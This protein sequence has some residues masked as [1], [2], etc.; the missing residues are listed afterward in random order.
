[1]LAIAHNGMLDGPKVL[2][3]MKLPQVLKSSPPRAERSYISSTLFSTAAK[4]LE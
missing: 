3:G 4:Q 1:M 2:L